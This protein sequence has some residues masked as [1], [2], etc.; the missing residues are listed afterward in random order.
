MLKSDVYN[1]SYNKNKHE[2]HLTYIIL[3]ISD[4]FE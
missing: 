3:I 2:M 1:F 4:F